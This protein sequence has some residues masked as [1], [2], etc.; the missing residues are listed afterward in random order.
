MPLAW[1]RLAPP[2]QVLIRAGAVWDGRAEQL[3]RD[4]DILV[5]VAD[6]DPS[7]TAAR[8]VDATD[9]V[10]MPGLIE[11]H[12]HGGLASGE[13]LGRRIYYPGAPALGATAQVE[14]EMGRAGTLGYDLIKTAATAMWW[15][16][17]RLWG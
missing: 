4:V 13:Q 12:A 14:L 15:G 9:G 11:M 3:R 2:E 16:C 6:R 5:E 8:V 17:S 10:V 7:R 1:G